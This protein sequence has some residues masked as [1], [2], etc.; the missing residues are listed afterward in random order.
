MSGSADANPQQHSIGF[1]LGAIV[2]ALALTAIGIAYAID[3]AARGALRPAAQGEV[4]EILARSLGG[5]EL[6]IP[7]TWFRYDEQRSEG[8]AKQI[9]LRFEMP[10]GVAGQLVPIEVTLLPRSR[11][12]PSSALL[13]GVYLHQFA[14]EQ[15]VG[16]PGLVGKPLRQGSGYDAEVVWYDAL[17]SEPFVAKCSRPV[18]DS[19]QAQCLRTVYLGPGIAAIYAFPESALAEWRSFDDLVLER[20][21]RIGAI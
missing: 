2:L 15:L 5:H 17:S 1:N 3:A 4:T 14:D 10:L 8:F 21:H 12:R 11:A 20:M 19:K 13:D 7:R 6:A 18:A 16:A 9:D